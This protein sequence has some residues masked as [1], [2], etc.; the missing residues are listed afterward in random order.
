MYLNMTE[1]VCTRA[2]GFFWSSSTMMVFSLLPVFM[3]TELGASNMSIGVLEG[4]ASLVNTVAK[5][6]S[7]ITSDVCKSRSR[8][9]AIG[10]VR[11]PAPSL[12]RSVG[13]DTSAPALP[14]RWAPY[15]R[16]LPLDPPNVPSIAPDA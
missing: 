11:Q 15:G 14:L 13:G 9:I 12:A 5:V 7:G 3:R 6:L 2:S 8:V 1:L 16:R 10:S 4:C